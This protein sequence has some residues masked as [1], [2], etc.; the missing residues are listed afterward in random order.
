[1]KV[2]RDGDATDSGSQPAGQVMKDTEGNVYLDVSDEYYSHIL[3]SSGTCSW[4]T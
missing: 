3:V 4:E 2:R 1:M